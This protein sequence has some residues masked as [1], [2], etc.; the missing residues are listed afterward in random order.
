M[1]LIATISALSVGAAFSVHA[2]N[3]GY[4]PSD[5][6]FRTVLS[7]AEWRA[8]LKAHDEP[9]RLPYWFTSMMLCGYAWQSYQVIAVANAYAVFSSEVG[10]VPQ[11]PNSKAYQL[12]DGEIRE[13][14]YV[15]GKWT[16]STNTEQQGGVDQPATAPGSKSEGNQ[17][18]EQDPKVRPQ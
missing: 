9:A 8:I 15:E 12:L 13:F 14:E 16:P 1:K 18:P 2:I 5:A 7:K 6:H 17:N 11:P 10:W 4:L 3:V